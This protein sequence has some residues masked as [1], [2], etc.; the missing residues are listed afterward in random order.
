M[1]SKNLPENT[2]DRDAA[3]F[4][5]QNACGSWQRSSRAS[6]S[7]WPSATKNLWRITL[8][9]IR[10]LVREQAL[11]TKCDKFVANMSNLLKERLPGINIFR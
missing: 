11:S 10:L 6:K 7:S 4:A 3:T 8:R 9:V 2:V 1:I 5:R